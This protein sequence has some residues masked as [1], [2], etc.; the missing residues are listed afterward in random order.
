MIPFPL[1]APLWQATAGLEELGAALVCKRLA[2]LALVSQAT[3]PAG[4]VALHDVVR[5]FLR[6]ELGP[7]RLAVLNGVL[8]D[9]VAMGAAR[10]GPA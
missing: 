10:S 9:A 7:Q 1:V 5:D 2:Q 4:G 6:A 3:G 8:V